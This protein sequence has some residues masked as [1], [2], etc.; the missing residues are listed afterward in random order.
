[1]GKELVVVSNKLP[2]IAVAL[3]GV[4]AEHVAGTARAI[5]MLAR[6]NAVQRT[7]FMASAIY[8]VTKTVSTYGQ[9]VVQ[10]E[11]G[12]YLLPEVDHPTN[13]QTAIVAAGA[14]YS[15]FVE[16]GTSRQSSQPFLLPAVE[17]L[18]SQFNS[19]GDVEQKLRAI[20]GG[21]S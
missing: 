4:M 9:G 12:S 7:G 6:Q 19:G 13:D 5:M 14:N 21:G 3:H 10:G 15:M 11:P 2:Q 17:N 18:A 16:M 1:M 8:R 20:I